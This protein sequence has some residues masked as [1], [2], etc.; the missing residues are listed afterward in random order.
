M[1]TYGYLTLTAHF[2]DHDWKLNKKIIN[3]C[4]MLSPHTGVVLSEKTCI[5]LTE[6]GIEEKIFFI[7]LDNASSNVCFVEILKNQ[8]NL[9][10]AL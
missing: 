4:L 9:K 10:G 1:A 2:V 3:L 5:L 7:T 8:L 6:W